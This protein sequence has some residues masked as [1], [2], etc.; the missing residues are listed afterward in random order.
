MS[1]PAT[2]KS[3]RVHLVRRDGTPIE[4]AT[5]TKALSHSYLNKRGKV[6]TPAALRRKF[7]RSYGPKGYEVS[8][9]E[10]Y[11]ISLDA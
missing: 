3:Y 11:E 7:T 10:V 6:H 2:V 8:E 5:G 9:I 4:T 1:K